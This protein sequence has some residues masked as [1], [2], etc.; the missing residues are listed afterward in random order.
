MRLKLAAVS[1]G[2]HMAGGLIVAVHVINLL[3]Q[4]NHY[5]KCL[6]LL[7]TPGLPQHRCLQNLIQNADSEIEFIPGRD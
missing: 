3:L 5:A 4:K 7:K 2:L 6:A 1:S